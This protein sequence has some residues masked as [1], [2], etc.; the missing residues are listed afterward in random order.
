MWNTLNGT[1]INVITVLGGSLIGLSFSSRIPERY[2]LIVLQSL[3]LVTLTLGIDAGVLEFGRM[4]D[5]FGPT[6]LQPATYGA[7][8][9]MTVI[10]CLLIGAIIGTAL[11]L[12]ERIERIGYWINQRFSGGDGRSFS[13][14][15]LTSSVLFCVGPLTLLGCLRN[16]AEG[17]P[18]YLYVKATLD[19]FSSIALASSLG[20][21]VLA[22]VL[23][24]LVVQSTLSLC[25]NGVVK[26]LDP[27]S[28][29]LMT[30]VG[31]I[32]LLATGL[33]LLDIK[34]IAVANMLP[35]ILLPPLAVWL[36][37]RFAPGLLLPPI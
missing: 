20:P 35:A 9:G 31:G 3:G 5:R 1:I 36:V 16:G 17:D 11:R 27:L 23:T 25:A 13:Q 4:I 22:S 34:K 19:G 26:Y 8:L 10:A 14:G 18:S 30:A 6:V 32:A 29:G 21:G 7:R 12:E 37:E 28:M 33:M 15:F 24:V 2:R